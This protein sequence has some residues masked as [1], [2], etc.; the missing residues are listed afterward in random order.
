MLWCCHFIARLHSYTISYFCTSLVYYIIKKVEVDGKLIKDQNNID[1]AEKDFFQKLYSEKVN[2]NDDSYKESLNDFL[3]NNNTKK[4][5]NQEKDTC[6]HDITEN[7]IHHWN[8]YTMAKP[9]VL[10][11][12][13]QLL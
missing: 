9:Q 5:T 1:K 4:L 8:N 12:F 7:E 11:A 10:M 6:D 13:P 3:I 2:S